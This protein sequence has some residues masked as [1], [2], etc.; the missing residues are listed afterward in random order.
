MQSAMIKTPH[1]SI[2]TV[3]KN[4]LQGLQK[5]GASILAQTC[6]DYEWLIIDGGSTDGTLD[7]FTPAISEDDKGIYDAMNK[8][9]ELVSGQYVLFLNAGDELDASDT[10]CTLSGLDSDFIYGD[11][12]EE[13]HIKKAR[14]DITAGMIT[15]HQAMLYRRDVIGALRF[16]T[17]LTIAADYDF[18]WRFIQTCRNTHYYP[19]AICR[20]ES[21]GLS[22]KR[23]ACGRAQQLII[24]RAMGVSLFRR[25]GIYTR[26]MIAQTVRSMFPSFFW[27][28]RSYDSNVLSQG[29]NPIPP[30]HQECPTAPHNHR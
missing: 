5:T 18:T 19:K 17:T 28:V 26:Q 8:G 23:A 24:R 25:W 7:Y 21:G 29:R 30:G 12:I 22:Q 16:D 2:V 1:F 13:S 6:G 9:I 11:A 4:N 3:T 27:R 14:H 15:H 10:L 20:F